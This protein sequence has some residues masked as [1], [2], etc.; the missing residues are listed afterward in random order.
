MVDVAKHRAFSMSCH[1]MNGE[2]GAT[3]EDAFVSVSIGSR[4]GVGFAWLIQKFDWI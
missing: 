3:S 4:K 1:R 2:S